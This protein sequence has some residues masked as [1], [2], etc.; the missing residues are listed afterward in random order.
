MEGDLLSKTQWED[1]IKSP[2]WAAFLWEFQDREDYLIELFKGN[3]QLWSP[4][5]VRGKLTEIDFVKQIPQSL[6][7][8]III[9][10]ANLKER[11]DS[12]DG[13][14]ED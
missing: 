9:K 14:R 10:E 1:F 2:I 13:K 4:D 11:E 8:S 3:D 12:Q 6:I 7:A 5:V